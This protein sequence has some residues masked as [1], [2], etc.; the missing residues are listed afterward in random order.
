MKKIVYSLSAVLCMICFLAVPVLAAGNND[1][2]I[3]LVSPVGADIRPVYEDMVV[4]EITNQTN[5]TMDNLLVYITIIDMTNNI[6]VAVDEYGSTVDKPRKI[7]SLAPGETVM[8]EIPIRFMYVGE[9]ELYTSVMYK[10]DNTVV[11]SAPITLNMIGDSNINP[12][13]VMVV[14]IMVPFLILVGI[15]WLNQKQKK[16]QRG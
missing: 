10:E 11:S 14:A 4:S 3:R 12:G 2:S 5:E 13:L 16:R 8:I 15:V 1:L 6:A 9:F 7:E